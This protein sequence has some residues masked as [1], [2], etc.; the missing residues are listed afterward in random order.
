MNTDVVAN[1]ARITFIVAMRATG[2]SVNT[3]IKIPYAAESYNTYNTNFITA[4]SKCFTYVAKLA[5]AILHP[6]CR[7]PALPD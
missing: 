5:I 2:K 7:N 4:P 3:E 1:R 6:L